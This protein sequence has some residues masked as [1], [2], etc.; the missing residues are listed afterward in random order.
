MA[1]TVKILLTDDL[2][3]TEATE[4]VAFAL[5]GKDYEID[6]TEEHASQMREALAPYRSAGRKV[7]R[8]SQ[9][10]RGTTTTSTKNSESPKIRAWAQDKGYKVGPRGRIHQE[11]VD[12]YRKATGT[13][14]G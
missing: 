5:D 2:E 13:N 1:Q 11:I 6:L 12:E 9:R 7:S 3:G 4:T 8:G 10:G 14:A